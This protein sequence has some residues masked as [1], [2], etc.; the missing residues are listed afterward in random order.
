VYTVDLVL[1]DE[2]EARALERSLTMFIGRSD[3]RDELF[4]SI[5]GRGIDERCQSGSADTATAP[6][7]R[8]RQADF[9]TLLPY[10]F[11]ACDTDAF[12]VVLDDVERPGAGKR[13]SEPGIVA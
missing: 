3:P 4:S 10:W 5:R 9:G 2:R 12:F 6:V 13:R 11:K 8:N 1:A 7:R